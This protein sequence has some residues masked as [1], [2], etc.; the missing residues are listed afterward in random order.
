MMNWKGTSGNM[1][2]IS[3]ITMFVPVIV[4]LILNAIYGEI[5]TCWF[6]LLTGLAFTFTNQ[7][8][9]KWIYNRFLKRRYK[10]MEGFRSNA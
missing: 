2:L 8:W 9:L 7:Y 6:M 10:N 3:M 1:L 5:V 4:M